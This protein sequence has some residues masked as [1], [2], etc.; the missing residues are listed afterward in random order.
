MAPDSRLRLPVSAVGQQNG[1]V[2]RAMTASGDTQRGRQDMA[3]K[4]R[5]A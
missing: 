4:S 2:S 3:G 1:S 5:S